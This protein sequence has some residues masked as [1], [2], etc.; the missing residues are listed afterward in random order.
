M[1]LLTLGYAKVVQDIVDQRHRAR[2]YS[3]PLSMGWLRSNPSVMGFLLS[4][5]T[6]WSSGVRAQSGLRGKRKW[7]LLMAL[8]LL[9][10]LS[11]FWALYFSPRKRHF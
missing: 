4:E 7:P 1:L 6:F 3:T 2:H 10:S 11:L 9:F 8:F 5:L